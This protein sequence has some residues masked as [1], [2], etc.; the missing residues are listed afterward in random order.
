MTQ[1]MA[2]VSA[3]EARRTATRREMLMDASFD[4]GCKQEQAG[5]VGGAGATKKPAFWHGNSL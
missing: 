5:L 1:Q 3:K 4:G 2:A